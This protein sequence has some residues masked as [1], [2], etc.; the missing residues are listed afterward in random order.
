MAGGG[1]TTH[2]IPASEVAPGAIS[3]EY[4]CPAELRHGCV[5]L[6]GVTEET[7]R[8]RLA[9]DDANPAE[10]LTAA[11]GLWRGRSRRYASDVLKFVAGPP[12]GGDDYRA[13]QRD[14][15]ASL[16]TDAVLH[17]LREGDYLWG[18]WL[19]FLRPSSDYV[20]ELI[21]GLKNKP[22]MLSE[23][24]LALGNSGDP[25]AL[26]PLLELLKGEDY[27]IP[28]DAAHAL[29]YLG[30]QE[31][32]PQ[33]LEALANGKGYLRGNACGALGR[34]GTKRSLPCSKSLRTTIA[35]PAR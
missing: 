24:I 10:K 8:K 2:D 20:P 15:E 29:G 35:T 9:D 4:L 5:M 32:E 18:T 1:P 25:R 12:P 33:L 28:G 6:L 21:A 17:E 27:W 31:A 19:A 26:E 16:K 30:R 14:V 13:F 23:T 7:L 3:L 34:I 11:R 22:E